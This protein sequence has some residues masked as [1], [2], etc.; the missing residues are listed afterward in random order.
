MRLESVISHFAKDERGTVAIL[1]G[2]AL[3]AFLGFFAIT[4][5]VGRLN[6]THA[7]LQSFAD[8]VAL[9]AAGELD[10]QPDAITRAANAAANLISDS[11]TFANGPTALSGVSDYTLTFHSA[12]PVS[13]LTPLGADLTTDPREAKF[14]HVVLTPK[15]V[16]MNLASALDKMLGGSGFA[17]VNISPE[18]VAG[19]SKAACD[20]SPLMFCLPPNWETT[21]NVGDQM[22]LRS[23]GN[24]TAWGPGNFGFIDLDHFHDTSGVCADE[25]GNKLA[26][27]IAAQ[28]QIT[29]CALTNGLDT[30][31]GQKVGITNA[32]FN[33]RFD[34]YR[35]VLNGEKNNVDFAPA[36]NVI[37]GIQK[38]GGGSCIQGNEEAT[39]DTAALG[40]DLCLTAGTCG[41][42]NRFGDG[43]WDRQGYL[44]QNHDL[45]DNVADGVGSADHLPILTGSDTV[46]AN[47][48][49]G[50]YLREIAYGNSGAT[51]NPDT[52]NILDSSLSETGRPMCSS[53]MSTDPAR[54]V[55]IAAGVDCVQNP[56]SGRTSGVPVTKFVAVFLTEPVGDDG[57]S[58]PSFDIHGEIVGFPDVSGVGSGGNGFGGIFRDIVQLYR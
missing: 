48:R 7:E 18:A 56:V 53:H 2:T 11:Q 44:D 49:Y 3:I 34:I 25:G 55:V 26:C 24:G 14:A 38:K 6:S 19:Y 20:I 40:R 39:I 23:G 22:L 36:P 41:G 31:P 15:S 28:D 50:M 37:K 4:L 12:L 45:A 54:R 32:A 57:G 1:W 9:A 13:D 58:P 51:T 16:S 42:N 33:V 43:V 10:G 27:L 29:Q 30:E 21:L 17:G 35:S 47:T 46:F 52:P 8:N 5:D